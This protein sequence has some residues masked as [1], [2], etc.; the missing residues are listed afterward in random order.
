MKAKKPAAKAAAISK[1]ASPASGAPGRSLKGKRASEASASSPRSQSPTSAKV[2]PKPAPLDVPKPI[3]KQSVSAPIKPSG[4]STSKPIASTPIVAPPSKKTASKRPPQPKAGQATVAPPSA[5]S[6]PAA[7]SLSASV[8]PPVVKAPPSAAS[9]AAPAKPPV[10]APAV[11]VAPEALR[12]RR[13]STR[14]HTAADKPSVLSPIAVSPA[15]RTGSVKPALE[16]QALESRRA[17]TLPPKPLPPIPA[18]LLEGDESPFLELS[19][20]GD[21]FVLAPPQTATSPEELP[22]PTA[23]PPTELPE[24][25]GTGRL[26]L[27]ARDPHWLYAH[28]DF[29]TERLSL[30]NSFS[31]TGHLLL[32]IFVVSGDAAAGPRPTDA[33]GFASATMSSEPTSVIDLTPDARS[34]FVPVPHAATIYAAELGYND[35]DGAWRSLA[36]SG[37]TITP[38]DSISHEP[39]TQFVTIPVDVPFAQVMDQ[40]LSVVQENPAFVQ[41]VPELQQL[42][43]PHLP[44]PPPSEPIARTRDVSPNPTPSPGLGEAGVSARD[45]AALAP[46]PLRALVAPDAGYLAVRTAATPAW[47]PAQERGLAEVVRLDGNRRLWIGSLDV[48]ELVRRRLEEAIPTSPSPELQ[49]SLAELPIAAPGEVSSVSAAPG[50]Q[51][52]APARGFWFN[53]NA[54]LIVYGATEPDAVLTIGEHR[55]RLRPDGTFSLR[56]VLPDGAYDLPAVA[57]SATG[58]DG[59]G[60]DLRFS[61]QTDYHGD[62]GK[63]PQDPSLH[64]PQ[65]DL[66]NAG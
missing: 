35:K 21:R 10:V 26:W 5:P 45:I 32:R 7:A 16:G 24:S 9:A 58:D 62:V 60:A 66:I 57:I 11:P 3:E 8:P 52:V 14:V 47:T 44:T 27:T 42:S 28:W 4:D 30:F 65:A 12:K 61:R 46:P 2:I 37:T 54:E 51:P 48:T 18:I 43:A 49:P 55:V 1:P 59:R 20:P 25:Y 13:L 39:S 17:V 33:A 38:P 36:L 41:V 31:R 53:V 64:P 56:F 19:G 29:S 40:V 6:I 22:R 15:A 23:A 34:W 50:P 63:T